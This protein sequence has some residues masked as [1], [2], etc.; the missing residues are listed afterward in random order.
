MFLCVDVREREEVELELQVP[1]AQVS[2]QQ[3]ESVVRQ[4][5]ALLHVLDADINM[6]SLHGQSDI[7]YKK[8]CFICSKYYIVLSSLTDCC[9]PSLVPYEQSIV[10]CL[11]ELVFSA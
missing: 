4:L 1:L 3:K 5:A 10:V 9:P 8:L 11:V 7:R 6:K 2:H